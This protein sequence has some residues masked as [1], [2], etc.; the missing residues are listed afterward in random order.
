M[1]YLLGTTQHKQT[2][3]KYKNSLDYSLN[4]CRID[5][6]CPNSAK[7]KEKQTDFHSG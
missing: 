5:K 6:K 4:C 2:V 7:N 3:L 1:V